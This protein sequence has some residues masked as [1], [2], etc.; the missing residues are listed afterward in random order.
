MRSVSFQ[1]RSPR[2]GSDV[3]PSLDKGGPDTTALN[4]DR[5]SKLT[6]GATKAS[7]P[8][9]G[10]GAGSPSVGSGAGGPSVG[11]GAGGPSVGSGAG[12]GAGGGGGR[13]RVRAMDVF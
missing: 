9:V 10:S 6:G 11:S 4:L 3:G 12:G 2:E 7:G 8:S 1:T 5:P 13:G